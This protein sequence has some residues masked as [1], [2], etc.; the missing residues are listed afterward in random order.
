MSLR[1]ISKRLGSFSLHW[2]RQKR[3]QQGDSKLPDISTLS[4]P[5]YPVL[6]LYEL[7]ATANRLL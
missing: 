5:C 1:G 2:K 7:V 6:A 4:L 3:S